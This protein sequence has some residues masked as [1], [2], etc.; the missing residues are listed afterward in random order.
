[1][2]SRVIVIPA[3]NE[4]TT[5]EG[6]VRDAVRAADLVVVVDDASRDQ[7]GALARQAGA[8]VVQHAI[9]RGLG[10]A[11]G[12]GISA[13][14]KLGADAIVTMDA[15]GQHRAIDAGRVFDRLGQGD[16]DFVLGSRMVRGEERG[17]MPW[18]RTLFNVFG[19]VFTYLLFGVWVTD[20][21]SGLR[22]FTRRAAS[23]LEL[24]TNGMEVSSEFVKEIQEKRWR[25]AE[26]AIPA[27]YTDYSLSKGQS[28]AM[29]IKT[30]S[31]LIIRRFIR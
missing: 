4:K 29:G 19:N 31:K 11:L 9:N 12:T 17:K 18:H 8:V 24:R 2:S 21:Q 15:D 13:A 26:I 1:M 23:E 27:I 25:L 3:Y 16:V 6:V 20:S 5:I 14:L 30:A 28:L 10:G 22:G 7:T